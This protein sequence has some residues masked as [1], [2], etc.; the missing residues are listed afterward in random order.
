MFQVKSC[1]IEFKRALVLG[2]AIIV[3]T[4]IEEIGG[5]TAKVRF[6]IMKKETN[7]L[8]SDGYFEYSL[9]NLATGRAEKIPPNV[10]EKYSV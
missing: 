9:V 3:R 8:S 7:K 1:F 4:W 5:S 2:E 10:V 6:E